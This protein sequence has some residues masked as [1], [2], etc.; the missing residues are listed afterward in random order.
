M[1]Y[2]QESMSICKNRSPLCKKD[3]LSV[4]QLNVSFR[5]P[6][7]KYI[8]LLFNQWRGDRRRRIQRSLR[9]CFFGEKTS[10]LQ[11]LGCLRR[12]IHRSCHDDDATNAAL[13]VRVV[14]RL[15]VPGQVER[16]SAVNHIPVEHE[17]RRH[18][19]SVVPLRF[20]GR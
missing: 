18:R 8:L 3:V 6:H 15:N 20:C 14:V 11:R 2:R 12:R 17:R 5:Q 4:A 7:I 19:K 10:R 13:R 9:G 16:V 1:F